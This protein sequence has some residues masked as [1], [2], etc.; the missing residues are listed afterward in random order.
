LQDIGRKDITA[1]V[2]FTAMALTAQEAGLQCL[3]F[4]SQ[5]HF[6]INSGLLSLLENASVAERQ[7]AQM[8]IQDH[9]MGELFKVLVLGAGPPWEPMGFVQGDRSHRL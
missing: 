8:L 2:D 6:L 7:Q 5:A 3:G 1:H 4:T 9:E